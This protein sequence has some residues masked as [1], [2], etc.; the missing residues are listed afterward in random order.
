MEKRERSD[1]EVDGPVTGRARTETRTP[2]PSSSS[3]RDSIFL[4]VEP[5]TRRHVDP[6]PFSLAEL[7]AEIQSL[8]DDPPAF[9][10]DIE[11]LET[12]RAVIQED[13]T[14]GK[15]K[16]GEGPWELN[17]CV[18]GEEGDEAYGKPFKVTIRFD[19][20]FWPMR[21]LLV[22][23]R[24]VFHHALTDDD[25]TMM[26]PWFRA[27]ARDSRGC[28]TVRLVLDSV[29]KLLV[30]P[31]GSWGIV[32]D[33]APARFQ[34]AIEAHRTLNAKRLAVM[35]AYADKVLHADLFK[36]PARIQEKWLDPGFRDA[37][38]LNTPE[39][40]REILTEHL[41]GEVFSFKLFTEA[42]CDKLVA[43]IFNFYAS[44][45]TARRPNSMNS[46]GIILNEI[47]LEPLIDDLQRV[48]QPL[49][50]LCFPGPGSA[51]DGHHCFIVRYRAG[52]DLGLDMHTDDSDVTFNICLGVEFSGAGLQFCGTMGAPNHRK[53]SLTYR[54]VRGSCVVHL[55]RK[56]HGADD[57][58]S[59]ERLNLILWN[60][61]TVYRET[62]EYTKPPY[63]TEDGPPDVVC[64]SY[65][66]DRDFGNYKEYPEGKEEK[67]KGRGW[68][69]RP[70][71]EYEGF[72]P[73]SD[74][75]IT[76]CCCD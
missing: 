16:P 44:G 31:L 9:V 12:A 52:E 73:D 28:C 7:E 29:H 63:K 17:V 11:K 21:V 13:G 41:Q 56:R 18:R 51:W 40:W 59:G 42:F 67:F 43:E 3:S 58:T 35:K 57:I 38:R 36:Q 61:S 1:D 46:Y 69:P 64:V 4:K 55:G 65:T 60:H 50:E 39:A 2:S 75:E 68:C 62:D 27:L 34:N 5:K 26:A 25:G 74:K 70:T 30:D 24:C 47:G 15:P 33:R 6:V 19:P 45:L 32:H 49:G 53:H 37:V 72:K 71:F 20:L 66:H 14:L 54:H 23:F 76:S 48:L 10:S 8:R 22:R